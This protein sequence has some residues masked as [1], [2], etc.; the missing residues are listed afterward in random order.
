MFL[1]VSLVGIKSRMRSSGKR[2]PSILVGA[3]NPRNFAPASLESKQ[4]IY[5]SSSFSTSSN[6]TESTIKGTGMDAWNIE[7]VQRIATIRTK[8]GPQIWRPL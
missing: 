1:H 5:R 3:L 7:R 2:V 6:S 8:I 4:Y